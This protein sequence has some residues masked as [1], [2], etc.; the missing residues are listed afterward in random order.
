M[1]E[2]FFQLESEQHLYVD[3]D[4]TAADF[5][6][7]CFELFGKYT[8]EF[9]N[10]KIMWDHIHSVSDFFVSL[11]VIEDF[12]LLWNFIKPLNPTVLTGA[13]KINFER[14]KDQKIIWWK[15]HFDWENVIVCLAK[16]KPLY[17]KSTNDILIDDKSYACK[18]W[19]KAGG[20]AILYRKSVQTM[21]DLINKKYF[22]L[23]I[24][25]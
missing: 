9:E 16:E 6:V 8:H 2:F 18:R 20:N 14:A 19:A 7:K 15:N 4:G 22:Q 13:P 23:K 17:M 3:S 21:D 10:E 24:P 11:P 1:N 12:K 25:K 5:E